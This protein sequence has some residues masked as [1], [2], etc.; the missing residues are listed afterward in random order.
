MSEEERLW[1]IR[2][3]ISAYNDGELTPANAL[4]FIAYALDFWR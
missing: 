2:E 3:I 4:M 1:R